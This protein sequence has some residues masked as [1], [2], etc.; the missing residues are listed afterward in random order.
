VE[1]RNGGERREGAVKEL[2][3]DRD[4]L[5]LTRKIARDR[6]FACSSYKDKCL[7][8]RIAVRMRARGAMTYDEYSALLDSDVAEYDQL[9][10]A[11]TINVTK[12]FRNPEVYGSIDADV[13]PHLW[14][15]DEKPVRLWSAGCSSGEEAY[16][17]AI[18]LH[19]FALRKQDPA[20]LSRF[21]VLGTDIDR[22]SLAAAER[23]SYG[24][25]AFADTSPAVRASY[26]SEGWPA[27][28]RD[29]VRRVV[30]FRYFDL[31]S[32][33]KLPSPFHLIL[34]RNVIIYFDR[35]SQE[36]LFAR[37]H[38]LLAPGGFLVLG[39]VETILGDAR[40]LF[41]PVNARERVFR[42]K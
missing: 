20:G 21:R 35:A 33:A 30:E 25:A 42:K 38:S 5:E 7:R 3:N 27:H 6:G 31:F 26:F 23:G 41:T 2:L 34:C 40:V 32:E 8:R 17:L 12:F 19:Q 16:S 11:L 22:P 9:L 18:L 39:K 10:Q 24:E 28:V 4:F 13:L 37:F 36:R 15:L 29:D 1:R 14:R